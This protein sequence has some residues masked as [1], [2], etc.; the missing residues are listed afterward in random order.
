MVSRKQRIPFC[1][2]SKLEGQAQEMAQRSK[3]NGQVLNL[4]KVLLNHP[5]LVRAWGRFGNYILNG[6]TVPA[7]EREIAILRIGW[8]NQAEYEW[9]QHVLIGKRAG[10]SDAEI[11]QITQ[12]PQAGWNRHEAALVQAADDLYENSVV[13]EETWKTLSET[14]NTEQMMDLIF[15]IGQY[16]LVSW[17]LN[18][19]GVPLDDFLPAAQ[20]K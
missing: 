5:K 13:S 10:L 19:F 6:S 1:D 7:R 12:G 4:F 8:L 9:E 16:N 18:S 17:V 2:L 11:D 14:Y 3:V 20:K 15:S